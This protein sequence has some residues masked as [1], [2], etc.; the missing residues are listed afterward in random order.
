[1]RCGDG[2]RSPTTWDPFLG[3]FKEDVALLCVYPKMRATA[4][5]AMPLPQLCRYWEQLSMGW[6]NGHPP[7]SFLGHRSSSGSRHTEEPRR[8]MCSSV[9]CRR[10]LFFFCVRVSE[11]HSS[12]RQLARHS[13]CNPCPSGFYLCMKGLILQRAARRC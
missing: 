7:S 13:D 1:M 5:P 9:P 6:L 2:H 10:D 11:L 4:A 12:S 8:G 3:G